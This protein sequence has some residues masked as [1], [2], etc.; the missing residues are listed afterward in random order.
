MNCYKLSLIILYLTCPITH[1]LYGM[2]TNHS[3][4]KAL[5]SM[6]SLELIQQLL[7]EGA[8]LDS[9]FKASDGILVKP[10]GYVTMKREDLQTL[11]RDDEEV[12]KQ[13]AWT[14]A[15]L[16]L[17]EQHT[18]KIATQQK[19]TQRVR[20]S[21]LLTGL[22]MIAGSY[23]A[24]R[25]L[26]SSKPVPHHNHVLINNTASSLLVSTDAMPIQQLL[27]PGEIYTFSQECNQLEIQSYS[28]ENRPDG[29]VHISLNQDNQQ[30]DTHY[31]H[32]TI[33][34][35]WFSWVW[36]KPIAYTVDWIPK[37]TEDA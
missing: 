28:Q 25:W 3:L 22:V 13:L 24:Y 26:L 16:S 21:L 34:Q 9:W 35:S 8:Q 18:A 33:T 14:N 30:F 4:G 2:H 19:S 15:I 31:M 11:A 29:I 12:Q 1:T 7:D 5:E 6:S 10:I 17:F 23:A 20:L 32:I 27:N 36:H 37:P